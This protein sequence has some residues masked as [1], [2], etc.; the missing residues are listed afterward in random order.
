VKR[1]NTFELLA[2]L[3]FMTPYPPKWPAL[4]KTLVEHF[5]AAR[6]ENKIVTVHWFRRMSQQ[7]W[8]ILYPQAAD[9]FV[10]SNGWV[11]KFLRRHGIM[12]RRITKVATRPPE[13]VVKVINCFIQYIRRNNRREDNCAATI[14][15]SSPP[16]GKPYF[17]RK[18]PNYLI[19][20]LDETPLSVEFLNGYSYDFKGVKTVAGKSERSGWDKR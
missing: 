3:L 15:R 12:R 1:R 14:L 9:I 10:F 17:L 7:I 2:M 11:W 20:N 13:E 4:E 16:F 5:T 19:I 6:A 18:F 8:Q